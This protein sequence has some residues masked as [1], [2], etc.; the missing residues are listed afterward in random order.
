MV[1]KQVIGGDGRQ[2]GV[3]DLLDTLTIFN[4][5]VS[6]QWFNQ[7]VH[8]PRTSSGAWCEDGGTLYLNFVLCMVTVKSHLV[9]LRSISRNSAG[10]VESQYSAEQVVPGVVLPAGHLAAR[11]RPVAY[12]GDPVSIDSLEHW[13]DG[14]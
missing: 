1:A 10:D 8:N 11:Y 13:L 7:I 3:V 2:N 12:S 9:G 6:G 4:Y 5:V 14:S